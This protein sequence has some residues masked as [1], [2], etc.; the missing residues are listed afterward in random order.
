MSLSGAYEQFFLRLTDLET[1]WDKLDEIEMT[2]KARRIVPA[3]VETEEALA[4]I[5]ISYSHTDDQSFLEEQK[6]WVTTFRQALETRLFQLLGARVNIWTDDSKLTGNEMFAETIEDQ[7]V[8]SDIFI[9]ILSPGYLRSKFAEAELRQFYRAADM[10]GGTAVGNMSR[11][12]K[13]NKTPVVPG[14]EPPEL[15]DQLGYNFYEIDEASGRAREFTHFLGAGSDFKFWN[16]IDDLAFDIKRVIEELKQPL[17]GVLPSIALA[18]PSVYLAE[19]TSDVSYER[20]NIKRD[21]QQYDYKVFPDRVLPVEAASFNAAVKEQL[22]RCSL[23][24][25][26]LGALYGVIPEGEE[27]SIIQIQ[28]QLAAERAEADPSFSHIIWMAPQTSPTDPRHKHFIQSLQVNLSAG[29][30]FLQTS[31]ED[32]KTRILE[33]LS[34]VKQPLTMTAAHDLI[35]VY[36]IFVSSDA[37][38]VLPIEQYF[39]DRGFEVISSLAEGEGAQAVQYHRENLLNCDAVF[40]YYGTGN[41][42][43]LRSQLW[44]LQKVKG[45]AAP[46][47]CA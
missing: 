21:L 29:T 18:R 5:F 34:R 12:F 47:Q 16:R 6:G 37:S 19:T 24:I 32:L 11:V 20:D 23:S 10:T 28:E 2:Q 26:L 39:F 40:I 7:I 4:N 31:F 43:W 41:Q 14:A 33:K 1:A 27:R 15:R 3:D 36:L 25:H 8:K 35:R 9:P 45:W 44:D 13:V 30:E 46:N 42:Q 17:L 38:A 22:S